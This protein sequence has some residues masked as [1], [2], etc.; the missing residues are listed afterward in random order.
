MGCGASIRKELYATKAVLSVDFDFEDG[1][2]TNTAKIAFDKDKIT[3]DKMVEIIS[4]MNEKQFTVGKTKSEDYNS[5]I[6][7]SNLS[8]EESI[9]TKKETEST[10]KST[11]RIELPNFLDIFSR[12][13]T[14]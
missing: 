4:T 6:S 10:I 14:G 1:R 13:S 3:V 12:I 11:S 8:N 9:S 2:K 5:K 7:S